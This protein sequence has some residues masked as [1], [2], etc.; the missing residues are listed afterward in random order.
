MILFILNLAVFCHCWVSRVYSVV[1]H[2]HVLVTGG[3]SFIYSAHFSSEGL[4]SVGQNVAMPWGYASFFIS[5]F[6]Q[7][8]KDTSR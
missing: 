1:F 2:V 5:S 8:I 3:T 4:T 6:F 7:L